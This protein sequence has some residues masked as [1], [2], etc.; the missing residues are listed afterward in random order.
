MNNVVIRL[1]EFIVSEARSCS[2]GLGSV[3]PLYFYRMWGRIVTLNEI[4]A[5]M[6]EVK[7]KLW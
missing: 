7:K 2:M 4:E 6:T 5:A 3:S 1:S